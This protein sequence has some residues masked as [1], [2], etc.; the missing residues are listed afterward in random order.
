MLGFAFRTVAFGA[1]G[2]GWSLGG[3]GKYV[4]MK[5]VSFADEMVDDLAVLDGADADVALG[6][7]ME[8]A[9]GVVPCCWPN[10]RSLPWIS[11]SSLQKPTSE[12]LKIHSCVDQY[13]A[14]QGYLNCSTLDDSATIPDL[15]T[16]DRAAEGTGLLN[17]RRVQTSTAGSNPALSA[18]AATPA[19][20]GVVRS[21]A[22][23][24]DG[25]QW[26][27]GQRPRALRSASGDRSH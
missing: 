15:G 3:I 9:C 19:F 21:R 11:N 27:Y 13:E 14:S 2:A 17:R 1:D 22:G 26:P 25:G 6:G 20:A 24:I 5:N 7:L 16:G 10:G 8:L 18:T 4:C 12:S 23:W